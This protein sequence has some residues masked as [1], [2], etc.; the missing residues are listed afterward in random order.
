MGFCFS[1]CRT[2]EEGHVCAD[3]VVESDTFHDVFVVRCIP[4]FRRVEN[5]QSLG[6]GGYEVGVW[7]IEAKATGVVDERVL[8]VQCFGEIY[9]EL[10]G[11]AWGFLFYYLGC[12]AVFDGGCYAGATDP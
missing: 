3:R 1:E 4:V 9:A 7:N 8:F 6:L 2:W 12:F 11:F 10:D 5:G